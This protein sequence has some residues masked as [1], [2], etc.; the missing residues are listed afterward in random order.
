MSEKNESIKSIA[1]N[2]VSNI[3]FQIILMI[4]S[5]SGISYILKEKIHDLQTNMLTISLFHVIALCI[6]IIIFLLTFLMFAYSVIKKIRDNK[7]GNSENHMGDY[8]FT[9]YEKHITIYKNGNGIIKHK[10]KIVANDTSKLEYLRRRINISDGVKTS[11]FPSLDKMKK[12]P[13]DQRFSDFGFW[14]QSDHNI[15]SEVREYYWDSLNPDRENKD[16]KNNPQELRWL[17]IIDK[18]KLETGK[19]YEV[20]YI[21]SVPGLEALDNGCLRNDWRKDETEDRSFSSMKITHNIKH[22]KYIVSFEDGVCIDVPPKC[23]CI[24]NTQDGVKTLDIQGTIDYDLL[25]TKYIF[26]LEN[27]V[28]SSNIRVSWKY[29]IL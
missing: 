10:F 21:A 13:K 24:I 17:F 14:Y 4:C 23:E 15:I 8:F 6:C 7:D 22:Y 20:S 9:Y 25:Y 27:P 16:A 12:T 18:N 19:P 11:K 3:I 5:G 29:N 2:I 1:I 26:E 28:F